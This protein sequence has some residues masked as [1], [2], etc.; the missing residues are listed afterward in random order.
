MA[1]GLDSTCRVSQ[2]RLSSCPLTFPTPDHHRRFGPQ[3]W[4]QARGW[5]VN[6]RC[7][8][9]HPAPPTAHE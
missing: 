2:P 1:L 7:P 3:W 6:V 5:T 4:T 9:Q 8:P